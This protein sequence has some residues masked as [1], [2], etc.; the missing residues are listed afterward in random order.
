MERVTLE[1]FKELAYQAFRWISFDAKSA[2]EQTISEYE[3]QLNNDLENIPEAE[4]EKYIE[5]YKKYFSAWLSS[6]ANCASSAVTGRARFNV[7][8]AQKANDIEQKYYEEFV[9]WREKELKRIIK[10]SKSES[11]KRDEEWESLKKN[12]LRSVEVIQEINSGNKNGF[13]KSAF[14]S[15]IYRKTERYAKKGEVEI[16]QKAIDLIKELNKENTIISE[17]HKFFKLDEIAKKNYHEK[18]A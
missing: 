6:C 9:K 2:A 16:V 15:S 5:N 13:E 14:V 10:K 1:E 17:R 12:I 7:K 4:R 11:Q 18:E 3:N 8:K